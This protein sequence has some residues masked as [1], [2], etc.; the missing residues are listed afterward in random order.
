[1]D[2]VILISIV[3]ILAFLVFDKLIS[4][5]P[6]SEFLK[7]EKIEQ[8]N[9]RL[10]ENLQRMALEL[11]QKNQKYWEIRSELDAEKRERN[12][13]IWKNK[14]MYVELTV[15]REKNLNLQNENNEQKKRLTKH[16]SEDRRQMMEFENKVLHL[17]NSRKALEDEKFRIRRE[18]EDRIQ[19]LE[20]ERD[21]MW[22]EHEIDSIAK[23]KE[24]CQ[25]WEFWF[26]FFENSSLP[27]SFDGSLK[28]DFLVEF[29]GQYIIFDAKMSKSVNLQNYINDQV[30]NTV[31]KIKASKSKDEIYNSV[32][33][34]IPTIELASLKKTHYYE[35]WYSFFIISVESFEPLLSSYKKI[36]DYDLADSF[37]P[38]DREN[39]VDL[40]AAFDFH[41]NR[42][43][44][45]DIISS[46]E[47]LKVSSLKYNLN[48]EMLDQV[49]IKKKKMRIEK[50]KDTEMK[51]FIHDPEE[52]ILA[53]KKL[54]IPKKAEIDWEELD[55][56]W[57]L[58]ES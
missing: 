14:Q 42:R 49:E 23:M 29:L 26:A 51:R 55:S 50:F 54:V 57:K 22:N 46:I 7:E 3:W 20:E 52:Q 47:W 56:A 16:D 28:P 40:I 2:I 31:K 19:R 9:K 44:S 27:S 17:E 15:L 24:V 8:E 37:D 41:I 35:G 30:K 11:E 13:Q 33:F 4:K 45:V 58:F 12:E 10:S 36:S 53:I 32:F 21:R 18:D 34:V 25:K 5:N 39:I 1:M 6:Q 38:Q 43:N 48:K